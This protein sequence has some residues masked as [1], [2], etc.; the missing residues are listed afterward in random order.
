MTRIIDQDQDQDQEQHMQSDRI[1][2][3]EAQRVLPFTGLRRR[4]K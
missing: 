3:T 1:G 4:L 2:L